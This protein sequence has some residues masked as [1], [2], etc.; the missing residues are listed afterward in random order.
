MRKYCG[1][2]THEQVDHEH[3]RHDYHVQLSNYASFLCL[4]YDSFPRCCFLSGLER[5]LFALEIVFLG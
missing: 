2:G 1:D 4:G 3:C 5:E